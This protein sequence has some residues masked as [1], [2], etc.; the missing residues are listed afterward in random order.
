MT[1]V[2]FQTTPG[3]RDPKALTANA[4]VVDVSAL[5]PEPITAPEAEIFHMMIEVDD[6]VLV[7]LMPPALHVPLP[8]MVTFVLYSC[9]DSS[10]GPFKLAQVRINTRLLARP[11]GL[12]VGSYFQGARETADLLRTHWGFEC[13]PGRIS[14]RTYHDEIVG[15][16]EAEGRQILRISGRDP[17][18]IPPQDVMDMPNCNPIRL[19]KPEGEFSRLLQVDTESHVKEATRSIHPRLE[20]IEGDAW[21][22]P[23]IRQQYPVR[24]LHY[25]CEFRIPAPR[26]LIDPALPTDQRSEAIH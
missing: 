18:P 2:S 7:P 22:V 16:V 9:P 15:I 14:I 12:L 20:Q 26:F 17:D 6:R 19:R 21:G 23:G 3:T 10:V 13:R 8:P 25:R 5:K 11:R 24:A 4:P 1:H